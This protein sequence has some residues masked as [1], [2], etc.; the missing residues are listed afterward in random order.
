MYSLFS[1]FFL[2]NHLNVPCDELRQRRNLRF[3]P[4]QAAILRAVQNVLVVKL[5]AQGG[6]V[7]AGAVSGWSYTA[8]PARAISAYSMDGTGDTP[9]ARAGA[10]PI[11]TLAAN[12]VASVRYVVYMEGCD[13]NCIDEA[14]ARDVVLQLAFAA[15]KA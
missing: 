7:V 6:V 9:T 11:C 14:Q 5:P 8:D 2:C 10:T 4:I 3:L 13:A 15:A 1:S 12:E